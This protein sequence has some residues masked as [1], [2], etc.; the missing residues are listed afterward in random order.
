MPEAERPS[1]VSNVLD[2]YRF[3]ATDQ[4]SEENTF[5][6]NRMESRF[7]PPKASVRLRSRWPPN[8]AA[9]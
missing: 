9:T 7:R 2:R 5:K 4:P 8:F 3:V 1:R 6:F